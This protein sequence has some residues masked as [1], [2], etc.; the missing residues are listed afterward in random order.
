MLLCIMCSSFCIGTDRK[1]EHTTMHTPIYT[2]KLM[3]RSYTGPQALELAQDMSNEVVPSGRRA[4]YIEHDE[5]HAL[6]GCNSGLRGVATLKLFVRFMHGFKIQFVIWNNQWSKKNQLRQEDSDR[7][8]QK[9]FYS[10]WAPVWCVLNCWSVP[11]TTEKPLQFKIWHY[12]C[13]AGEPMWLVLE[14][15][16]P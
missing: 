12:F 15:H 6:L 16:V 1:K 7:G 13:W 2:L 8:K 9:L 10:S 11:R 5:S 14:M 4:I 3:D